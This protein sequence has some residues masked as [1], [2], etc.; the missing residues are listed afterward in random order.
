[1]SRAVFLDRDGVLNAIIERDGKPASPRTPDELKIE[2]GA[3][4]VL[5]A[6]KAQGFALFVVTNQPDIRRGLMSEASLEAIHA[7]LAAALPVDEILACPHD[8]AD[9]CPCRKPKPG[10]ILDLAQR[11]GVDLSQ[12]WMIG[13]QDRDI[14]SGKAAGCRTILLQRPYN[15]GSRLRGGPR[16]GKLITS[17]CCYRTRSAPGRISLRKPRRVH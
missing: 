5:T 14:S 17:N 16:V 6:L 1:M 12:S 11:H 7:K 3:L 15:A 10:L 4:A 8:T 13:D 2:A 9:N